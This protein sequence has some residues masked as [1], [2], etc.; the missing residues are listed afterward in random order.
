MDNQSIVFVVARALVAEPTFAY[1]YN[2]LPYLWM[3]NRWED[4][5]GWLR[6]LSASMHGL[7]RTGE[8]NSKSSRCF[9]NSM[10]SAWVSS[11][12]P[13]L[14]L[15]PFGKCQGVPVEDGVLVISKDGS[16]EYALHDSANQNLHFLPVKMAEVNDEY[17][18][19]TLGLRSNSLLEN[20]L[21]SSLND[22]Q[23]DVLQ[24][25]FGL[26]LVVHR[27][28]N[29]ERM[30]YMHG[31]GGN[32]KGVVVG[33][34][35]AL[36]TEN[37][38]GN[39]RLNDLS[40]ASNLELLTGKLAMIGSESGPPV[41]D[42]EILKTIVSW[43]SL[44]VNPKYRDP[45][46]LR[47]TCLV[48]QAS[49]LTPHFNDDSDAMVRRVIAL[50]MT[51][52]SGSLTRVVSLVTKIPELEYPLLV[53]WSLIGA[54]RVIEAGTLIVP[55]S[56]ETYS[57]RV[58]RP[59]RTVDRFLEVLEYGQFEISEDELYKAYS[60]HSKAQGLAIRPKSEFFEDIMLRLDRERIL[61]MR[62][63][64]ATGYEAQRY[65]NEKQVHAVLVPALLAAKQI[66]LFMGFRI[67]E[68]HFGQAIGQPIPASRRDVPAF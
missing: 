29:P 47:P 57:A 20:F 41:T 56:V 38:V 63:L 43:E 18:E 7:I 25:W 54:T 68:G 55:E 32:G 22:D 4:V 46:S 10:L 67:A 53:A 19:L 3:G 39:L 15:K 60:L 51:H 24:Q 34:L 65:I 27:V 11:A 6:A 66:N 2:N 23:R 8:F 58:V 40:T 49:N 52:K 59:V 36:V 44:N 31:L 14:E 61:Y 17:V 42:H 62:R 9:Y 37:A 35:K 16:I 50:N 1:G 33:L 5:D 21:N 45:F 64:K 12:R 48:T 13:V 26:H 28:G 30:V